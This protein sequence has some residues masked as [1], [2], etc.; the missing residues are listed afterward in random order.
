MQD[1][2]KVTRLRME[3]ISRGWSLTKVAPILGVT[4]ATVANWESGKTIPN[5]DKAI[6]LSRL[7]DV[8]VKDLFADLF[9]HI[10]L[11]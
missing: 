8:S 6:E 1:G 9:M 7:Y 4:T 3:R 5:I 10:E 11:K 2:N